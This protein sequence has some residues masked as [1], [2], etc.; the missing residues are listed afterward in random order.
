MFFRWEYSFKIVS[1]IS[2]GIVDVD[3]LLESESEFSMFIILLVVAGNV[4]IIAD[5]FN[6]QM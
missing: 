6:I 3:G 2:L 1:C 5:A 4:V